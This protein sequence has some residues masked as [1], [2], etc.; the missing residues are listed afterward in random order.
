MGRLKLL[1]LKECDEAIQGF[2]SQTIVFRK[3]LKLPPEPLAKDD[4]VRQEFDK[5]QAL[6]VNFE[7]LLGEAFGSL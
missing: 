6:R 3:M 5:V 4:A 2:L 7:R 1:Q